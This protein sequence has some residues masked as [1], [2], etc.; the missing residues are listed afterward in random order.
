[1][2]T[3][4]GG[5]GRRCISTP[6]AVAA[7]VVA[8]VAV[9]VVAAKL[10]DAIVLF[11]L[12]GVLNTARCIVVPAIVVVVVVVVVGGG[13]GGGASLANLVP[14]FKLVFLGN[15]LKRRKNVRNVTSTTI[16]TS[17]ATTTATTATTT[18]VVAAVVP[19]GTK[20]WQGLVDG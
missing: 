6:I 11:A 18:A 16:T 2:L 17:T 5:R 1:V 9:V 8:V 15:G 20:C 13:G 10:K 12:P 3:F 4:W 19:R 14:P 7:A